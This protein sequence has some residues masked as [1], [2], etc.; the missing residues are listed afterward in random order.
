MME[1]AHRWVCEE[2]RRALGGAATVWWSIEEVRAY[3]ASIPG[4]LPST[5]AGSLP[6]TSFSGSGLV[7]TLAWDTN[8]LRGCRALSARQDVVREAKGAQE[9]RAEQAP[10]HASRGPLCGMCPP[11]S[12][13]LQP[14]AF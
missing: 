8:A 11:I 6:R 12:F 10:Q 2:A 9:A 14:A 5:H 13:S 3:A 1:A 4:N 7:D